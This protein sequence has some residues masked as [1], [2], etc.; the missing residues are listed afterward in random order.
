MIAGLLRVL[1]K[2]LVAAAAVAAVL[3]I[4][5][6]SLRQ[7]APEAYHRVLWLT[8]LFISVPCAVG[9]LLLRAF[10]P[11]KRRLENLL[12]VGTAIGAL[13]CLLFITGIDCKL[14]QSHG[15]SP[16]SE[17]SCREVK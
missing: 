13:L 5:G 9:A 11:A 7:L 15:R 8:G 2:V 14:T 4:A 16:R 1:L 10:A 17:L 6:D 12:L 3:T